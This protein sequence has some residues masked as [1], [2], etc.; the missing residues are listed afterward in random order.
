MESNEEGTPSWEMQ[1]PFASEV[2]TSPE[3]RAIRIEIC[4]ACDS[5]TFMKTCKE[6]GC[7]MPIKTWMTNVSCPLGKW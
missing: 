3:N 7:L 5:L 2:L 1:H 4:R 6:C